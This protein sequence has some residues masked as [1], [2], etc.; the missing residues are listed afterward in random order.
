MW[1]ADD[2]DDRMPMVWSDLMFEPQEIS[3][4]G[5]PA[6]KDDLN[7]DTELHAFHREVLALRKKYPALVDGPMRILGGNNQARTFAWV[8]EG[9]R[10]LLAVFNRNSERQTHSLSIKNLG[11]NMKFSP[12][13]VSSGELTEIQVSSNGEELLVRVPGWTGTLLEGE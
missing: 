5:Q 8:R 11:K 1:G 13:F 2:P 4:A 10:P 6:R 7:F 12:I 9:P 3:P